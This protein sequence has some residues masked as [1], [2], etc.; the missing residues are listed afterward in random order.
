MDKIPEWGHIR[1]TL[2]EGSVSYEIT[3]QMRLEAGGEVTFYYIWF[4][5]EYDRVVSTQMAQ[6]A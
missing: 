1:L 3:E 5:D 2:Q 4:V 6:A